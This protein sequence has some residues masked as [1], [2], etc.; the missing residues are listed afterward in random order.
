MAHA[1]LTMQ[2]TPATR[3]T[4][5]V[6]LRRALLADAL[7]SG[8]TGVAMALFP[9]QL[10]TLAGGTMPEAVFIIGIS[11]IIFAVFVG[12][13][14][15]E[16]PMNRTKAWAIVGMNIVYVIASAEVLI[17]N[18]FGMNTL[19]NVLTLVAALAVA[20]LAFFQW[21]GLRRGKTQA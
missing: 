16:T 5:H 21:L 17:S 8:V 10:E 13:T 9:S 2:S 11:F 19:G 20:D 7:I 1:Q 6:L 3:T 15:R 14:A 18:V 12:M 4:D